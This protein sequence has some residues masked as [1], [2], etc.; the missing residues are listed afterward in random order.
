[1]AKKKA[2]SK[3][4]SK[5]KARKPV[6][7]PRKPRT[8]RLPGMEDSGI[9]ELEKLAEEYADVRDHRMQ[10]SKREV[11]LQELLLGVMKKFQKTEYHHDEVHCWIKAKDERVKVKIG[12][13]EEP[14]TTIDEP[15]SPTDAPSDE[16]EPS[17][18]EEDL[19]NENE[20]EN[21]EDFS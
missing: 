1:M 8:P 18:D 14:D 9:K 4:K 5:P 7:V 21:E 16:P 20:D 15:E 17:Q 13:M 19:E 3:K 11:E 12:E 10:L 6:E 2:A